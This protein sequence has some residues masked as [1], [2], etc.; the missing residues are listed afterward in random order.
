MIDLPHWGASR[1]TRA[2][3]Q[4]RPDAGTLMSGHSVDGERKNFFPKTIVVENGD[5]DLIE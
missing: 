5:I 3:A 4:C 2:L 1:D